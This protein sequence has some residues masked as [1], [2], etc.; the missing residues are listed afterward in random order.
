MRTIYVGTSVSV[1][2]CEREK[3]FGWKQIAHIFHSANATA[4]RLYL[5]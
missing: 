3:N 1:Q 4:I 2:F 5:K